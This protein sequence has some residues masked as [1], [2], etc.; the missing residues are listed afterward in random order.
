MNPLKKME[1]D[2]VY[3][4]SLMCLGVWIDRF[5]HV[6]DCELVNIDDLLCDGRQWVAIGVPA[7]LASSNVMLLT[8]S[9]DSIVR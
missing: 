5:H 9:Q 6:A 1:P 4:A 2:L 7:I 3:V 8:N